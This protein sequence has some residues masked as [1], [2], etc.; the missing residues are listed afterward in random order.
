MQQDT[1][2]SS[3]LMAL[4]QLTIESFRNLS[5]VSLAPSQGIN[6]ILGP[7]GSGKTSLL[8]AIHLLALGRSF[9]ARNIKHT[10]QHDENRL[11]I[12]ALSGDNN[13]PI[14]LEYSTFSSSSSPEIRLNHQP[15]KRLSELAAYLPL[16]LI[17]ANCHQFFEQ[18]PRYRRQ[19]LDWSLFHVEPKFHLHWQHYRRALQQRNAAIRQ[20][21]TEN[22]VSTWNSHL[23]EHGEAIHQLR[24]QQ[25][26]Q[27]KNNFQRTFPLL[28]PEFKEAKYELRYRTGWAKNQS[29]AEA[30]TANTTRDIALGYTRQGAHAADWMFRV[31]DHNPAES[32]SRGQQKLFSLA[33]RISQA[34]LLFEKNA[35]PSI[36]LLDDLS[37]ELDPSHQQTVLNVI[38]KLPLQTFITSTDLSLKHK[39]KHLTNTAV[40]HVEQGEFTTL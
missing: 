20:H 36:L 33:L 15:V 39:I 25:L 13:T 22:E 27:L 38:A 1:L 17:P 11:R 19:L 18:G 4:S 29:L 2:L 37:S 40:F 8:E 28:C 30:L 7:N 5:Q 32:F 23:A 35:R 3:S 26:S 6:L 10:L 14:G 31:N 24:Q 21:Q 12:I 9:R 34:Q 16:Q